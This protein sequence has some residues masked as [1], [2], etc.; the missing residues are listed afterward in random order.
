VHLPVIRYINLL[1]S[2]AR[3]EVVAARRWRKPSKLAFERAVSGGQARPLV[4]HKA[5]LV[6]IKPTEQVGRGRCAGR[7]G[8]RCWFSTLFFTPLCVCVFVIGRRLAN[9]RGIMVAAE[10]VCNRCMEEKST[11]ILLRNWDACGLLL[12]KW[13][14]LPPCV[15]AAVAPTRKFATRFDCGWWVDRCRPEVWLASRLDQLS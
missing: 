5:D 10:V 12:S 14:R 1:Q 8:W 3:G 13:Y 11:Y 15:L 9:G 4:N 2:A 7:I 6:T